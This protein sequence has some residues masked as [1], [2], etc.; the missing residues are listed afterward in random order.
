DDLHRFETGQIVAAHT[1]STAQLLRRFWRRHRSALSIA[2]LAVVLIAIVVV[3]AFVRTN[4]QR[5]LAEA[6]GEEARVAEEAAKKAMAAAEEAGEQARSRADELTL[7]QAESDVDR[8]PNE[9]LA[10]LL[11]LSPS[12]ADIGRMRTIAADAYAHGLSRA[13]HGHTA[14]T[15]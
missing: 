5:M 10:W 6:R 1:Y 9:A 15:N 7:L 3:S 8:D 14:S 11:T 4:E 13:L 12:F 2:A